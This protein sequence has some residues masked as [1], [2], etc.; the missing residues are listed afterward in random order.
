[1]YILK[2]NYVSLRDWRVFLVVVLMAID[3]ESYP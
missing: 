1:M 2:I 3:Y